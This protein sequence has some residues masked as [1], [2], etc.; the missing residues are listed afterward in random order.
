M[1]LDINSF[2]NAVSC[3]VEVSVNESPTTPVLGALTVIVGV[4]IFTL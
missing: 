2:F 1:Y 4:Y 3:N